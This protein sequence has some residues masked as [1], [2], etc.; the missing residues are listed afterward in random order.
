[1]PAG[2]YRGARGEAGYTV[3][4]R[5]P[6]KKGTVARARRDIHEVRLGGAKGAEDCAIYQSEVDDTIVIE[7][8]AKRAIN[9]NTGISRREDNVCGGRRRDGEHSDTGRACRQ[10][11][12]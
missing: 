3:E 5:D 12:N 9:E 1:M 7:V 11:I 8:Q 4:A 2:A 6:G 10:R